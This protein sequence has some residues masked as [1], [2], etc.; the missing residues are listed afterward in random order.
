MSSSFARP[1]CTLLIT[2]NSAVLCSVSF[3]NRVVSS[4]NR[5]FSNATVMLLP[6]VV[7]KRTSA[8]EK[9]SSSSIFCRLITPV[10]SPP[11]I[12]GTNTTD[13]EA[14]PA[15]TTLP[16]SWVCFSISLLIN[17]GWQCSTTHFLKPMSGLGGN[18]V[19]SPFS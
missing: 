4:N 9:A 17:N 13:F 18:R 10:G 1:S 19:R 3:S 5:A 2:A 8:S 14:A 6:R 12:M 16:Y 15:I 11:A 7:S